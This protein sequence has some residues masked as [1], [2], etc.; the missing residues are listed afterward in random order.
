LVAIPDLERGLPC[1]T[2]GADIVG[3]LGKRK[4]IEPI[5]LLE[6]AKDTEELFNFLVDA[7]HFSIGLWMKSDG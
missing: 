7:F 1:G 6:V 5:V 4:E 3:K 2:M